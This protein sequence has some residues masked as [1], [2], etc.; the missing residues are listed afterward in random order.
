LNILE[1]LAAASLSVVLMGIA[2]TSQTD[3]NRMF[4][5]YM[6]TLYAVPVVYLLGIISSYVIEALLGRYRP[7]LSGWKSVL[8]RVVCYAFAGV[9][10]TMVFSLVMTGGE[11]VSVMLSHDA[12]L[13][14]GCG[15]FTA[16][17]FSLMLMFARFIKRMAVLIVFA[18]VLP[19]SYLFIWSVA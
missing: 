7:H 16:V 8:T 5:Y 13:F 17:L 3:E 4:L 9:L 14:Y 18:L 1:K 15:I 6:V 11:L 12:W 2:F 10:S 19:F